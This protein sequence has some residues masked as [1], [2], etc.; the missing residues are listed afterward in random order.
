MFFDSHAHYDDERFNKDRDDV[1]NLLKENNITR[2][3]NI[4]SDIPSS[5]NA[6]KLS[7]KYDFIYAS[8]GVHP[9]EAEGMTDEDILLIKEMS[10]E[11]KVVAIGEI[12][13]DYYYDNSPRD[14][15]KYWFES[16][17]SL[18]KETDMPVVI[19][20]RDATEDTISILKNSGHNNC[21]IH[22]FSG[23]KE[24]AKIMLDMGYYLSFAGPVTFKNAKG[25]LDVVSFVPDDRFFIET[26]CPYLTPEPNRGKRN[27]SVYMI[28]TAKKIAEI[29]N[30]TLEHIAKIT[31]DNAS[32][33]YRI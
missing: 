5:E 7:K 9:H 28:D 12:G 32:K 33:F 20:M 30:T 18:A 14:K 11:K 6:I 21:V 22:C 1:F 23:S 29:R 10:K 15:Q 17:L 2:V 27:N 19:H 4:G 31:F 24:T 25:I 3:V 13:L 8:V 16:Q 26:D